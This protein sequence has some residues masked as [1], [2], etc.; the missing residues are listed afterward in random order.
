MTKEFWTPEPNPDWK[1]RQGATDDEWKKHKK[2][3]FGP[4]DDGR[5]RLDNYR[6]LSSAITPRPIGFIGTVKPNGKPNLAPFSYFNVICVDPPLFS[7]SFSGQQDKDTLAAIND[8][9]ELT[10]NIIS[11]WFADAANATAVAAPPDADEFE[12]TGLTPAK[13]DLVKAP[14]VA[15]SGFSMEAKLVETRT[16]Y[17]KVDPLQR[18]GVVVTV[19]GIKYH[20]R[21][22]L[23]EENGQF[24][25]TAKLKPIGRLGRN[26]YN[27]VDSGYYLPV[28]DYERDFKQ[29]EKK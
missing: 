15:E 20:I 17:S 24:V 16:Y 6:L 7:I 1:P 25:D 18:T 10:V 8:S 13:S 19:E 27:T 3:S 28:Y 22:D 4:Y 29:E 12:L 14:H 26:G 9:G 23:L 5:N 2:V 21:E 11:E